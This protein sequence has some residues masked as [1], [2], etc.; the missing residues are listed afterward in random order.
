MSRLCTPECM[1]GRHTAP[2]PRHTKPRSNT[3]VVDIDRI[4]ELAQSMTRAEIAAELGTTV[5][6]IRKRMISHGIE[7]RPV[8]GS[9]S[10]NHKRV[11]RVRGKAASQLCVRC[12]GQARDWAQVHT[13]DGTDP[14][15][16]F[17]PLCRPCH[18]RYDYDAHFT[19]KPQERWQAS[20]R[21]AIARRS[22]VTL[23]MLLVAIALIFTPHPAHAAATAPALT[24]SQRDYAAYRW[25]L[26]QAGKWYRYGGTG[27]S[28]YDCSG[29]AYAAYLREGHPIP[30]TTYGMLGSSK[31]Y[32]VSTPRPGDLA[33]F[34]YGHVEFYA[35]G[36]TTFGAHHTG[37][38]ISYRTWSAYYHPTAFYRVR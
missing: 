35:G 36:H 8:S 29:L 9:Y 18:V 11:R 16:D 27:P 12:D 2:H 17:V 3:V 25:A 15:A 14:W 4:R 1:C 31:L 23:S 38:R 28:T 5:S 30:R 20:Y 19:G 10:G 37:T 7:C 21:A 32:R 24:S 34:G 33:F 6:V 13:E 22:A 26:T